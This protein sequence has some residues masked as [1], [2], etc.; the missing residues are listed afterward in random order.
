M[1]DTQKI[2][3]WEQLYETAEN[4]L[5]MTFQ[6]VKENV[7]VARLTAASFGSL[8]SFSMAELE[9]LKVAVSEGVSNAIIHGYLND[10]QK[11]V[12]MSL[13]QSDGSILIIIRDNGIGMEDVEKSMEP[14]YSTVEDRMG[15]G[16]VFM[17]SFMDEFIVISTPG[18]GT[19]LLM[20][21]QPQKC[22]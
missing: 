9:E 3:V 7:A 1:S 11:S 16:F 6:S 15:L 22:L 5:T 4:R 13:A 8:L 17:K 19:T 18:C 14:A 21:K 10:P 12:M 2:K 20:R